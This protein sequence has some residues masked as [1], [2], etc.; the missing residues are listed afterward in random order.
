MKRNLKNVVINLKNP[1]RYVSH[2]LFYPDQL[3][4]YMDKD[5]DTLDIVV[6]TNDCKNSV[7]SKMLSRK[8]E[9]FCI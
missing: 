7:E 8:S 5:Y 3:G 6:I 9:K 2:N 1:S 4:C